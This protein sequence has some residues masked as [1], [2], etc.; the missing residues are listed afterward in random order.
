MTTPQT[1]S[2]ASTTKIPN[3]H[4]TLAQ[5]LDWLMHLHAQEIDLGLE[6]IK[7]VAQKMDV[8]QPAPLVIT[9][10]GTNGKGSSVA[11]L[12]SIL[13]EAGYQVGSYTSPHIQQFN[14]RIQ[15]NQRPVTDF[16]IVHAF[17]EIEQAREATKLTYFEFSTLAALSI[18][19][20]ANLD[21][22]VLEVGL[23]GRLD[24]VNIVDANAALITAIDVDHI[25]WLGDNRDQ[26]AIEKA[27]VMRSGRFAVCSDANPPVTLKAYA[28][29]HQVDLLQLGQHFQYLPTVEAKTK[30]K[31]SLKHWLWQDLAMGLS[32]VEN[33]LALIYPKLQGVFQLQ[34]A[35][36]VVAMILELWR[37]NQLPYE[38][39]FKLLKDALSRGLHLCSHPGRLQELQV[40]HHYWLI[41]VAHNPQSAQVLAEFLEQKQFAGFTAIF[42]VL[43]DKDAL[44]M[45]K[46]LAPFIER[47]LIA[48]LQNPRA[49]TNAD[50]QS[51]LAD[52]GVAE[53]AIDSL[54]SIADCVR[55]AVELKTKVLVFGSFFTVAQSFDALDA[56]HTAGK[57][58]RLGV[59]TDSEPA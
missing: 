48:D 44:P 32:G 55:Q 20:N 46:M 57:V 4:S 13:S 9:V 31:N 27:G 21:V 18:F 23:G 39:S 56:L 29:E 12:V 19:K 43:K 42:S 45:V 7:R 22:V 37:R 47:W 15:L 50:L 24:A 54:D 58:H 16:T 1:T 2:A 38:I 49:M 53:Q 30:N 34:N 36:G 10:A 17:H 14:E 25:E 51:L 3:S 26:I 6:R 28:Q 11:M 35:S 33:G 59:L 8:L 52:A 5:W 40:N 41:D